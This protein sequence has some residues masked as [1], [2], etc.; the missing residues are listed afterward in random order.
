MTYQ[1]QRLKIQW[2]TFGL[3]TRPKQ[4]LRNFEILN[5]EPNLSTYIISA[6]D[7]L[8]YRC[9]VVALCCLIVRRPNLEVAT[10]RL[11]H[12]QVKY[13]GSLRAMFAHGGASL[14]LFLVVWVFLRSLGVICFGRWVL[15]E[16]NKN[17]FKDW[18]LINSHPTILFFSN[19]KLNEL[20]PYYQKHVSQIIFEAFV[21][22]L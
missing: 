16:G 5:I 9:F 10:K 8:W 20:W 21:R 22:I 4:L 3:T 7:K 14:Q 12:Q 19:F 17:Y 18:C 11:L 6:D 15:S 13:W 1:W 2:N